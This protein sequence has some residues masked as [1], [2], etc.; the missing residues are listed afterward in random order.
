MTKTLL[1]QKY[2][3]L[4]VVEECEEYVVYEATLKS[5]K[6]S[7]FSIT[8]FKQEQFSKRIDKIIR[9]NN[10]NKKIAE[11]NCENLIK[12]YDSGSAKQGAYIVSSRRAR[13]SL[14]D[15]LNR[16]KTI[17]INKIVEV[18]IAV[19]KGLTCCHKNGVISKEVVPQNIFVN[20]DL[21]K[22]KLG[23]FGISYF[24]LNVAAELG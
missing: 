12:V 19:A 4:N 21:T 6:N 16:S 22:I 14:N 8:V 10:E 17:P 23:N 2:L 18:V 13:I 24:R 15:F 20:E 7:L 9:F 1:D 3:L 11:L 5:D